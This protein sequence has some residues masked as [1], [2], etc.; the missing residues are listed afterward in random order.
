M[1]ECKLG[2]FV[3]AH[4]GT[5]THVCA[6]RQQRPD[7]LQAALVGRP[8]QRREAA[9]QTKGNMQRGTRGCGVV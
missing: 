7:H 5:C 3:L 4:L 2:F 8:V 9:L 6:R 1:A